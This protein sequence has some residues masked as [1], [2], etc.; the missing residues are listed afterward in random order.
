MSSSDLPELMITTF[1]RISNPVYRIVFLV[2]AVEKENKVFTCQ[3]YFWTNEKVFFFFYCLTGKNRGKF[4]E[5]KIDCLMSRTRYLIP[6]IATLPNAF[7][8]NFPLFY[9]VF[10]FVSLSLDFNFFAIRRF[11]PK[12]FNILW[13]IN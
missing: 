9:L 6:N 3:F 2:L 7:V 1:L 13:I 10:L 11:F 12:S 8:T 5:N 4:G